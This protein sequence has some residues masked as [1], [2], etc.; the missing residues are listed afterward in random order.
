MSVKI[1]TNEVDGYQVMYCSTTMQ[2]FG[3]VLSDNDLDLED[4]LVWLKDN[5]GKDARS[6]D[7][8]ALNSKYY[9]WLKVE[10][11]IAAEK[12]FDRYTEGLYEGDGNF[13]DNH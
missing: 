13:A 4:F 9:E 10:K 11:E 7:Q 5:Y 1:I 2:A 6:Y 8:D 3:P 12:A